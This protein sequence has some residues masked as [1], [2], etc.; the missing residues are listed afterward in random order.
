MLKSSPLWSNKTNC[1]AS[2]A[3][4]TAFMK[5]LKSSVGCFCDARNEVDKLRFAF[6]IFF[7][8]SFKPDFLL[9]RQNLRDAREDFRNLL[10][11]FKYSDVP[12]INSLES[13]YNFQVSQFSFFPD[14]LPPNLFNIEK[15]LKWRRP[16]IWS[17]DLCLRGKVVANNESWIHSVHFALVHFL[18][19]PKPL[20]NTHCQKAEKWG[21]SLWI[22]SLWP[23]DKKILFFPFQPRPKSILDGPSAT[24]TTHTHTNHWSKRPN[25]KGKKRRGKSAVVF[26][27][28]W[29][30]PREKAFFLSWPWARTTSLDLTSFVSIC[31]FMLLLARGWSSFAISFV[32]SSTS[33]RSSQGQP[34]PRDGKREKNPAFQLIFARF[35]NEIKC[36]PI[37]L[38]PYRGLL[39]LDW[40]STLSTLIN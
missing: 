21:S 19:L 6:I 10:L 40:L 12:S 5:K 32:S 22:G 27:M 30:R 33:Y 14:F 18:E 39:T 7:F 37:W 34:L 31:L 16:T 29:S 3:F 4:N 15:T 28:I 36:V 20:S 8:R 23:S 25:F 17:V 11:G 9:I 2:S 35:V 1:S 38:C 26:F 13:V 24:L